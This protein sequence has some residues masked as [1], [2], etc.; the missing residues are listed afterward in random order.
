MSWKFRSLYRAGSLTAAPRKLARKKLDL[1]D[2]QEIRR[3]KG[4]MVKAGNYNFFCGKGNENHKLGQVFVVHHRIVSAV[5][6]VEFVSDRTSHIVLRG[7]CCNVI[8]LNV[9][10]PSEEKNDNSKDSF[11]EELEQGFD[12]FTKYH[13][14]ILLGDF[15]AKVARE[16]IFKLKIEKKSLQQDSN[17]SDVRIVNF[18]T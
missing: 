17:C 15:N 8:V 1:V 16:N 10:A 2:V 4:G 13:M 6:R 11:C 5:K 3:D 18:A 7:C 9:N 12:H 14:K